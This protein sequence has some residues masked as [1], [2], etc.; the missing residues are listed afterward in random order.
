MV[1]AYAYSLR[2]RIYPVIKVQ[3]LTILNKTP[4]ISRVIVT[5]ERIRGFTPQLIITQTKAARGL[6]TLAA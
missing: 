3:D 4:N 1:I 6:I 2:N 5:N